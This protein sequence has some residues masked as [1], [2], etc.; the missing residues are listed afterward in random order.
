MIYHEVRM[1]KDNTK[2][3]ILDKHCRNTDV[4]FEGDFDLFQHLHK[5]KENIYS[6]EFGDVN[7]NCV[8]L[9][10]TSCYRVPLSYLS[11]SNHGDK[12]LMALSEEVYSNFKWA[13]LSSDHRKDVR[14]VTDEF[15]KQ[16]INN[17]TDL[18]IVYNDSHLNSEHPIS[19]KPT[20]IKATTAIH[21]LGD[22]SRDEADYAIVDQADD[23]NYYGAWL[24][25]MGFIDVRFPKETSQIVSKE[26]VKKYYGY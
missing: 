1:N 21:K 8:F 5:E 19:L 10:G 9:K 24:E 15:Y 26:E 4:V 20:Y 18:Q 25:G 12:Y 23:D 6:V 16:I 17:E 3:Y 2:V 11:F 22:I 7:R 13:F 14:I